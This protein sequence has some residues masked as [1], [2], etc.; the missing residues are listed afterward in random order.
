MADPNFR[1][2]STKNV[3]DH[4]KTKDARR[5]WLPFWTELPEVLDALRHN[6]ASCKR[7]IVD[8]T[9]SNRPFDFKGS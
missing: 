4:V 8:S 9:S 5:G 7:L 2:G 1:R 3:S 6:R